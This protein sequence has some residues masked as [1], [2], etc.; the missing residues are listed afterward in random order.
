MLEILFFIVSFCKDIDNSFLQ[1]YYREIFNDPAV[2]RVEAV[3]TGGH[4]NPTIRAPPQ[5]PPILPQRPMVPNQG[6][7]RIAGAHQIIQM[8]PPGVVHQH[9]GNLIPPQAVNVAPQSQLMIIRAAAVQ[10]GSPMITGQ[11]IAMPQ[12]PHPMMLRQAAP[13]M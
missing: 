13:G 4:P 3:P 9:G 8:P 10:Q 7:P 6:V 1:F 5:V 2:V 12:G 11:Q